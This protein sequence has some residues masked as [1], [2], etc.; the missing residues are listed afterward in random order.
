MASRLLFK[1]VI[2]GCFQSPLSK[3]LLPLLS[4]LLLDA[5][6]LNPAL[7]INCGPPQIYGLI[8]PPKSM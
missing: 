8:G 7:K 6:S 1:F 4:A 2:T 3:T 5:V